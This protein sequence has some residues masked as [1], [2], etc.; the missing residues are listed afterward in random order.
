M[1]YQQDRSTLC[2][3]ISSLLKP[4][5]SCSEQAQEGALQ[6]T[7]LQNQTLTVQKTQ[8]VDVGKA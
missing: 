3:V 5:I 8:C 7:M 1:F 2:H 6:S 4:S